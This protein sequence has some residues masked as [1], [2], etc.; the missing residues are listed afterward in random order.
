MTQEKDEM[1]ETFMYNIGSER[2]IAAR[3]KLKDATRS[4][5]GATSISIIVTAITAIS[6]FIA[7]GATGFLLLK[8]EKLTLNFLS[9]LTGVNFCI[10]TYNILILPG[11]VVRRRTLRNELFELENSDRFSTDAKVTANT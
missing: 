11:L 6:C 10:A 9:V 4:Y 1:L 3:K 2:E 7:A 8:Q 5:L